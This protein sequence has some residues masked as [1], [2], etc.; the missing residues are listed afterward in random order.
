MLEKTTN[1]NIKW[2]VLNP[3]AVRWIKGTT[4]VTLQKMAVP[5]NSRFQLSIVP[6]PMTPQNPSVVI[7]STE[8]ESITPLLAS[9]F[10]AATREA[11]KSDALKKIDVI[12]KLLDGI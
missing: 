10:E 4:T 6:Q 5:N 2:Q 1:G 3:N 9:I 7:N 8:D 11:S 12:K